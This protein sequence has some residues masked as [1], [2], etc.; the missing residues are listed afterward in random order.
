[1]SA[2]NGSS[3]ARPV[4]V[5]GAN[6]QIGYELV[7]SLAPL[8]PILALNRKMLD[9]TDTNA[10]R[11]TLTALAPVAI[12]NAAAYTAVDKA[13]TP[14]GRTAAWA[15]NATAVAALARIATDNNITLVHI[16]SDYVYVSRV[17]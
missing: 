11:A 2:T 10:V 5:I 15:I 3:T 12:V 17:K 8:A 6:G 7:K 13:E 14:E 1:M 9:I 4:V 16:S